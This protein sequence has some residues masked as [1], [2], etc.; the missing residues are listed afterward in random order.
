MAEGKEG[1]DVR[2]GAVRRG[3]KRYSVQIVFVKD[4]KGGIV[5]GAA[6]GH[7][8]SEAKRRRSRGEDMVETSREQT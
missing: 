4:K 5:E 7:R 6:G 2:V 8:P 3:E 1:W